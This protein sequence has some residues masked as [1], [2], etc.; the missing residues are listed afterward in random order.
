MAE[1]FK[2][3]FNPALADAMGRHLARAWDAFDRA[4]FAAD[5]THGME[6]LELKARSARF[7]AALGRHLPAD[8][9]AAAAVVRAALR[10]DDG[11]SERALVKLDD[12]KT[13]ATGLAG[14]AIMPLADWVAERGE[15]HFDLA[16]ELL[17]E[18]TKRFSSE[19]AIRA[20]LTA[21]PVETLD[22][23]AAW[24]RDPDPHV[25]RLVSE[26]TRPRLPWAK[27]LP[28]FIVDPTPI[29]SLLEALKDDPSEY[30]RRSVAN[31]LND[32]AKDHPDR[33]A[34]LAG[35][36]MKNASPA[37]RKL[38][39]HACRS[40]IKAGHAGA[41][42]ALGYGEPD[43]TLEKL[44]IVTSDVVLGGA[45]KFIAELSS[46]GKAEQHLILDYAVHHMKANGK[47]TPKVFK[48]KRLALQPGEHRREKR[49]HPIKPVTTRVYHSGRHEVEILVNGRSLGRAAFNL[50][51]T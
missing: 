37:R 10:P 33:A 21:R 5:A 24:T 9:P 29:L 36:W 49:R 2:N 48:W 30:V 43:V 12:L 22:L 17:R 50:T 27:R 31:N 13:D 39:R 18:M 28:A 16:M 19:F 32:I 41:L 1:P 14:W 3:R 35:A 34:T 15:D 38:V 45:L 40:L 6:A 23:L 26:G 11:L 25:R 51:A 46:S 8:F 7:T 47:R 4:G 42:E 20:F 44:E